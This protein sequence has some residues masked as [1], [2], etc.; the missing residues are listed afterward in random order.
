MGKALRGEAYE[1]GQKQ[2]LEEWAALFNRPRS[3]GAAKIEGEDLSIPKRSLLRA[4]SNWGM[5]A[6]NQTRK[7]NKM[8]K[9]PRRRPTSSICWRKDST[10]CDIRRAKISFEGGVRSRRTQT[11]LRRGSSKVKGQQDRSQSILRTLRGKKT[12]WGKEEL[13]GR[14]VWSKKEEKENLVWSINVLD[15]CW[16]KRSASL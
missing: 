15:R 10:I 6:K 13:L 7:K 16:G 14:G 11:K 5:P 1:G 9:G 8:S 2:C 3:G 12:T 4:N